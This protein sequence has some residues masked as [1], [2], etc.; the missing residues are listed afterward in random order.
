MRLARAHVRVFTVGLRSRSSTGARCRRLAAGTG[1]SYAEESRPSQLAGLYNR[2]G[3]QL[4]SEY[5]LRYRSLAGPQEAVNVAVRVAGVAGTAR[6]RYETPA[7][8]A[9]PPTAPYH[10]SLFNRVSLSPITAGVVV[11]ALRAPRR[12]RDR[13]GD[14]AEAIA[15][16]AADVGVRDARVRSRISAATRTRRQEGASLL[17]GAEHSLESRAWWTR[18]NDELE[19][20]E[21]TMPAIQIV[22]AHDRRDALRLRPAHR[23][24]RVSPVRHPALVLPLAVRAY[25]KRKLDARRR[26]F[27]EQLPDS[28]QIIASA[29]R[30]GHSLAASLSVVV[31]N[32]SEPMK[33]ELQRVIAA[34]QLGAPLDD[35][36][37]GRRRADGQS[38]SRPARASSRGSSGRPA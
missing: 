27:A 26:Q 25:L 20:A 19:I 31:E 17:E 10:R 15:G 3:L 13:V 35:A 4:A 11:L 22:A 32:A 37:A 16:T 28:L 18:F 9:I 7:L 34:E 6:T 29:L 36:L 23:R 8:A 24:D 12:P 33:S 30:A 14:Q 2:L 1:G 5:L 21:I 38:R